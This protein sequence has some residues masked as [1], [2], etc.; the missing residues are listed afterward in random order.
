MVY[1]KGP[2]FKV[3]PVGEIKQDIDQ[4]KALYG[5][6]VQ[7]LFFP[8]GNTIAMPADDLADICIYARATFPGLERI[9]VYGSSKYVHRQGLEALKKL[10]KSGLSRI[11]VGLESGSDKV[12]NRVKKGTHSAEQIQAG[13]WVKEA[14]IELSEYVMLGIGGQ[15][16]THEHALETASVLNKI[17]PDFIRLRTF[18]PKTNTLLL[19]QIKKGRFQILSPHQVLRET[20]LIIENLNVTSSIHS[21]HYTNY[22]DVHGKMP[23]DRAKMLEVVDEAIKMDESLFRP[24]YVGAQ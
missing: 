5:S 19:H 22:V 23:A 17:D 6:G 20:R 7:T 10:R 4:A 24:I 1:K 13:L 3:R 15:E 8:A 18:L 14:G 11:H 12:L 21:D 2:P 16:T 9:T